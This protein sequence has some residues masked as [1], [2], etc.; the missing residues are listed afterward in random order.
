MLVPELVSIISCKKFFCRHRESAVCAFFTIPKPRCILGFFLSLVMHCS[1]TRRHLA[2][3]C[4]RCNGI[5]AV[6]QMNT[7]SEFRELLP[8]GFPRP[9][10]LFKCRRMPYFLLY[11]VQRSTQLIFLYVTTFLSCLP[12]I[13]GRTRCTTNPDLLFPPCIYATET[14]PIYIYKYIYKYIYI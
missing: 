14:M 6:A 13:G 12:G 3:G 5:T 8:L 1:S 11:I 2:N 4:Y 10:A 9:P 7:S